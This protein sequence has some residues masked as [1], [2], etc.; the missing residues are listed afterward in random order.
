MKTPTLT[1]AVSFCLATATFAA[2][3]PPVLNLDGFKPDE[4]SI[5]LWVKFDSSLFGG[6]ATR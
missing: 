6:R 4:C 5:G 1:L 3:L 2:V